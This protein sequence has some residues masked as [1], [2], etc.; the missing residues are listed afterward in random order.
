[1]NNFLTIFLFLF[2]IFGYVFSLSCDYSF[3]FFFYLPLNVV[4]SQSHLLYQIFFFLYVL[5]LYVYSYLPIKYSLFPAFLLK[6][7]QFC[8]NWQCA[9]QKQL[10]FQTLFAEVAMGHS[11]SQ[12]IMDGQSGIWGKLLLFWGF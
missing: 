10:S 12:W 8:L 6:E 3:F 7:P 4:V 9:I 1:M 11:S 5:Y 2:Y